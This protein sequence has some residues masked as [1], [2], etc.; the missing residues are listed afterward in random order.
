MKYAQ[1]L[2]SDSCSVENQPPKRN[3]STAT[4]NN[5]STVCN[6]TTNLGSLNQAIV[7][8][9]SV[10]YKNCVELNQHEAKLVALLE[11]SE[12][13]ERNVKCCLLSFL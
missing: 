1:I 10:L 9:E 3:I 4:N 7:D 11:R 8:I 6:P 13:M 2:V 5:N 12:A